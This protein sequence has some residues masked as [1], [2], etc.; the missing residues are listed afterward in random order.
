MFAPK[1]TPND[2]SNPTSSMTGNRRTIGRP[3][4]T[5]EEVAADSR[6]FTP[7]AGIFPAT[8]EGLR[9]FTA[10]SGVEYEVLTFA[11]KSSNG[12]VD[13]FLPGETTTAAGI[14]RFCRVIEMLGVSVDADG[15]FDADA[16]AGKPCKVEIELDNS[17][18]ARLRWSGTSVGVLP[19]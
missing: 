13:L 18:R 14:D 7:V 5:Q 8:C 1:P 16:L 15:S 9:K 4:P 19:A 11:T 10:K 17:G 3:R 12:K 6:S 2:P